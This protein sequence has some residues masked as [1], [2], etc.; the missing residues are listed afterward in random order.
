M[1]RFE[2]YKK[3]I[4]KY[5]GYPSKILDIG[6]GKDKELSKYFTGSI[7]VG[8]DKVFGNDIENMEFNGKYDLVVIAETLEHVKDCDIPRTKYY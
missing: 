2:L 8:V 4:L 7:Y 3:L 5:C 1:Y 6:C